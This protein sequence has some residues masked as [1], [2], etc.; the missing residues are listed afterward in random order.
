MQSEGSGFP[1][2]RCNGHR[3]SPDLIV[4]GARDFGVAPLELD[5][6]GS[7]TQVGGH[8]KVCDCSNQGD[9]SG[10]V[11]EDAVGTGL[12]EGQADEDEG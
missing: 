3:K 2:S 4:R 7:L 10:D 6:D 5:G 9:S 1:T 8:G 12:G 11:V